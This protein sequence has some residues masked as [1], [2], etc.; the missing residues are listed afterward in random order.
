M[1]TTRAIVRGIAIY[2]KA[3]IVFVDTP[4]IFKPK[5]RLDRAMVST[6]WGG[7]RDADI[8]LFLVDAQKGFFGDAKNILENLKDVK[9]PK[10]LII[11]K[12][13]RVKPENIIGTFTTGK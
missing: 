10:W 11:N 4:G 5:R 3:Q 6:A 13:D 12:I 2:D 9:Q 7:A 8:I 1:Q